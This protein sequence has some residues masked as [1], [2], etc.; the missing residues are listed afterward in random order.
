M[1]K[2]RRLRGW[3]KVV[4]AVLVINVFFTISDK[5]YQNDLNNCKEIHSEEYCIYQL[6]KD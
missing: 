3:V 1:K 4:L 2:Q 5:M 6:N